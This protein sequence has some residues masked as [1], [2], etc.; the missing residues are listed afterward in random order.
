MKSLQ[1]ERVERAL[2]RY[3]QIR[4][5]SGIAQISDKLDVGVQLDMTGVPWDDSIPVGGV[6]FVGA[7]AAQLSKIAIFS[8]AT[9]TDAL[10]V[11]DAIRL[12]SL[13]A[14]N[15]LIGMASIFS[16]Y[17]LVGPNPVNGG[18]A[19]RDGRFGQPGSTFPLQ[20][21]YGVWT[22]ISVGSDLGNLTEQAPGAAGALQEIVGPW[23][24]PAGIG[25]LIEA[26]TVNTGFVL[27]GF[28]GRLWLTEPPK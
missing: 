8:L 15:Y 9:S 26:N 12:M 27:A 28:S 25:L 24:L 6:A 13:A 2:K 4:G 1:S 16:G 23:V 3:L 14:G 7:V 10:M 20:L 18:S 5:G 19:W 22:K 17:T 21:P 11:V